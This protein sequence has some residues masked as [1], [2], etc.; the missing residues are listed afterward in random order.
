MNN[1]GLVITT[2]IWSFIT[3]LAVISLI[4][5]LGDGTATG[6]QFF[7][8]IVAVVIEVILVKGFDSK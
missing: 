4:A 8:V 5:C 2:A 3:L 6:T 1:L 7:L